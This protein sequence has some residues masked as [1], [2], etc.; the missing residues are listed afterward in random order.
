MLFSRDF[1][2]AG[3]TTLSLSIN[4]RRNPRRPSTPRIHTRLRFR[5]RNLHFF[6]DE[7]PLPGIPLPGP[8][9]L[10]RR[11]IFIPANVELFFQ[12]PPP[13]EILLDEP[14]LQVF[15]E[16]A[17]P[18]PDLAASQSLPEPALLPQVHLPVNR[19]SGLQGGPWR[20][21]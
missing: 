19:G 7:Q 11:P 4:N 17:L 1:T 12:E 3:I 15:P 14:A 6:I 5:N 20:F 2:V 16:A 21:V 8:R 18:P 13:A 10:A 9:G